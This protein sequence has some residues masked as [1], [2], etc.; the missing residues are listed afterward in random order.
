MVKQKY[1]AVKIGK[2]P[3]I[4]STW[5]QTEEQVKGFS[6]A[7]YKSFETEKEAL[8]YLS[9]IDKERSQDESEDINS[10]NEKIENEISN[11]KEDEV[12]AFVDG[13]YCPDI[14][15]KEKYSFGVL[16][17][18]KDS[19]NSLYKAYVEKEYIQSKN[20]AGEIEGVKQAIL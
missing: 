3:G 1:Y 13:S 14:N 17:K 18:T 12:I 10:I 6:G 4:Y 5:K 15:G 19:E 16:L 8:E 9:K 7:K 20:I 11:L 2:S